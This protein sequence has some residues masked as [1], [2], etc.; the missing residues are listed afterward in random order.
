MKRRL[1]SIALALLLIYALHA[2]DVMATAQHALYFP[3]VAQPLP[4]PPPRPPRT[5]MPTPA[6]LGVP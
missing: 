4:S 3:L 2:S 1:L 5:P 6:P